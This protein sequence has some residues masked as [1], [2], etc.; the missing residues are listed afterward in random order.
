MKTFT[1]ILFSALCFTVG[2][3]HG[4]DNKNVMLNNAIS[5]MD[6]PYVART[7]DVNDNEELVINCDEVDCTTFVEYVLAMSL[8]PLEDGQVAEGDFANNLQ[9]IRY[10]DGKIDGY[11]S[12]LHYIADWINNG[13]RYGLIQDISGAR[14]TDT[15]KLSITYMSTHPQLYKQL[16]NS[17][18]NVAKMKKIEKALS[19][20]EIRYLP[21]DK[22][23]N[24]GLPWINDGDII[25]ITTNTPGLD[26]AHLGIAFYVD[27]KL[28]LI[29][30]SSKEKKV[31]VSNI[32]LSQMLKN[33]NSWTG[34]RVLRMKQ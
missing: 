4:Q 26:V 13:V 19:G 30:A 11:T 15:Q 6:V 7:L 18:G 8:S 32:A 28:S 33:N 2:N 34:I 23:P 20:K 3:V 22:L 14:C 17:P 21:K 16:S 5:F 29:H 31:I 27:G 24:E 25:A 1:T 12:R 9:K 10:R